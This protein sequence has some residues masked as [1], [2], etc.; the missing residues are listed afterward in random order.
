MKVVV[1]NSFYNDLA[2]I[3]RKDAIDNALFYIDFCE[4]AKFIDEAPGFKYLRQYK[5]FGRIEIAPYRIGVEIIGDTVVFKR[6]LHREEI[7]K[8][9]P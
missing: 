7:Y 5:N 1:T 9:F 3:K 2:K 4:N 6:I 8:Q